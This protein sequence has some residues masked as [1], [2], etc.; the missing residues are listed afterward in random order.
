MV[1]VMRIRRMSIFPGWL[2]DETAVELD[3][4]SGI[5]LT[6]TTFV[7][8]EIMRSFTLRDVRVNEPIDEA[9]GPTLNWRVDRHGFGNPMVVVRSTFASIDSGRQ[10]GCAASTT[11]PSS[12]L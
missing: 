6:L 11:E 2:G 3:Q 12:S 8:G 10:F 4:A 1:Q 7:D 9:A 5:I